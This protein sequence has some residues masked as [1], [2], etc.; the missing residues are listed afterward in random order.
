MLKIT[1]SHSTSF[2]L[3]IFNICLF[4]LPF[5]WMWWH[6][7]FVFYTF[8][9]FRFQMCRTKFIIQAEKF[10]KMKRDERECEMS[11]NRRF[12]QKLQQHDK[13]F[14]FCQNQKSPIRMISNWIFKWL[15]QIIICTNVSHFHFSQTCIFCPIL[16]ICFNL[17]P[18]LPLPSSDVCVCVFSS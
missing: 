16:L 3:L 18:T 2:S 7:V 14:N 13:R 4:L 17:S 9:Y 15:H 10:I 5:R 11:K 1:H 12:E 8:I 6:G